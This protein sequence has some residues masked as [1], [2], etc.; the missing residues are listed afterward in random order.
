MFENKTVIS[1]KAYTALGLYKAKK[2]KL[3]LSA[4]FFFIFTFIAFFSFVI[5]KSGLDK[6]S[7]D[8]NFDLYFM[9]ALFLACAVGAGLYMYLAYPRLIKKNLERQAASSPRIGDNSICHYLFYEDYFTVTASVDGEALSVIKQYYNTL[10]NVCED[11]EYLYI[12]IDR[13]QAFLLAKDGMT[14]SSFDELKKLLKS[15]LPAEKYTEP[16]K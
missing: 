3:S 1:L 10:F 4:L 7:P 13:L 6:N 11:T 14:D 8:Y 15:K 12:Y 9:P 2:V 16:K 5:I